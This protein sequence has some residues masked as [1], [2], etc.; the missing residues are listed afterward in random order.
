MTPPTAH[1]HH[2]PPGLLGSTATAFAPATVANLGLGF[3]VLGLAIDGPGDR[4][5]ATV[6]E[7]PPGVTLASVTDPAGRPLN[8]PTDPTKNTAGIAA[9][10][11][12]KLAGLHAHIRLELVKGLPIGSGMGSSAASA[13]AAALAT[14]TALGSPLRRTDL[15]HAC[16]EAEAVVAG[17]HADN[18]APAI[19]GGLILVRDLDPLSIVRL[20]APA[21]LVIVV[22][23]PEL[24]LSTAE[25]RRVLPAHVPLPT[26]VRHTANLAAFVSACF[27]NDLDLLRRC[28]SDEVVTPARIG[29]I[30]GGAH[31][32]DAALDAGALGSSI[33]GS[34]PA[35]FALCRGPLVARHVGNAMQ[36]A[37]AEHHVGSTILLSDIDCPGARLL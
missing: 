37:F 11:T 3:D 17:R 33:S 13:A 16:I 14:N 5:T 21:G 7:G 8:L 6:T 19:L 35:I 28:I 36:R 30:K 1:L 34:G 27:T 25:A 12:L 4:A 29:L 20:P 23:S 32:I 22:A 26:M 10:H 2:S 18:A 15:I 9:L 31:A 24:S